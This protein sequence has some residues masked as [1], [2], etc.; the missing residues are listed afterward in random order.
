MTLRL[1][2]LMALLAFLACVQTA[3]GGTAGQQGSRNDPIELRDCRLT[4][5]SYG[6][7]GVARCQL[8]R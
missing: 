6:S 8:E 5:N 4:V 2:A 3:C 1:A 7:Q